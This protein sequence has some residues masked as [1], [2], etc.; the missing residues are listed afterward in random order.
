M[1]T[2]DGLSTRRMNH[3]QHSALEMV[4]G[5]QI[6]SWVLGIFWNAF[7]SSFVNRQPAGKPITRQIHKQNHLPAYNYLSL[8]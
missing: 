4:K 5:A 1:N 6:P 8:Q 7:F 3:V 2:A